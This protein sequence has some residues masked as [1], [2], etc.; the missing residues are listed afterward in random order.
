MNTPQFIKHATETI[1]RNHHKTLIAVSK[2]VNQ[3]KVQNPKI[4]EIDLGNY[5]ITSNRHARLG[6]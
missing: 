6:I 4:T 1:L 2:P 3:T 5:Q